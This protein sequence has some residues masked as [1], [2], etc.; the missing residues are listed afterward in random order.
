MK[1]SPQVDVELD[2]NWFL[3]PTSGNVILRDSEDL[4]LDTRMRSRKMSDA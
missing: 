1:I 2:V 4:L 3:N